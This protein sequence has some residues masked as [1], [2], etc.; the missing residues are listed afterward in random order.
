[1]AFQPHYDNLSKIYKISE[2]IIEPRDQCPRYS[3]PC[4][5]LNVSE[6]KTIFQKSAFFLIIRGVPPTSSQTQRNFKNI[7]AYNIRLI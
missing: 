6:S 5:Y 7:K 2:P 1:M 4:M 3:G